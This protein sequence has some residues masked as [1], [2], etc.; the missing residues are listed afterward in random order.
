MI[1]FKDARKNLMIC[2]F[3]IILHYRK[4]KICLYNYLD[5]KFELKKIIGLKTRLKFMIL[6]DISF[7]INVLMF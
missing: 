2:I 7:G 4:A 1:K 6:N 3:K 5:I